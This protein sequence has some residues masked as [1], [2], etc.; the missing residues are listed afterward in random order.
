MTTPETFPDPIYGSISLDKWKQLKP[1]NYK[2][3]YNANALIGQND[4]KKIGPKLDF[5]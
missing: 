5:Y 3:Y 1:F 2:L 4:K